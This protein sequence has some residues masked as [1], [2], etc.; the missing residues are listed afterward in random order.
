MLPVAAGFV[1]F[2][3]SVID[4]SCVPDQPVTPVFDP[5]SYYHFHFRQTAGFQTKCLTL[6]YDLCQKRLKTDIC[7]WMQCWDENPGLCCQRHSS[8][9]KT[10]ALFFCYIRGLFLCESTSN[11]IS[12]LP[13]HKHTCRKRPWQQ[14]VKLHW[15]QERELHTWKD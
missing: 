7:N 10:W 14:K 3:W 6:T 2:K 1:A 13:S 5:T 8:E 12:H 15:T 4:S 9:L 11:R